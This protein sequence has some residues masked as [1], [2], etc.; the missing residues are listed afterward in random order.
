[1]D[2]VFIDLE[3]DKVDSDVKRKLGNEIGL[4]IDELRFVFNGKA[5]YGDDRVL[6]DYNVHKNDLIHFVC[7]FR[8]KAG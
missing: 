1:M 8:G 4:S 6:A 2:I 7:R 3:L 5:V